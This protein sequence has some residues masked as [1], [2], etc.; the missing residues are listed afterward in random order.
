MGTSC[1]IQKGAPATANAP[2]D[3][4]ILSHDVTVMQD[5]V[6]PANCR[7]AAEQ[8]PG[9]GQARGDS[10]PNGAPA[11]SATV[12]NISKPHGV[13]SIVWVGELAVQFLIRKYLQEN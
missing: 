5:L 7:V 8:H 4:G 2:Q 3:L 11:T 9:L 6:T 12:T 13:T 10:P 1:S